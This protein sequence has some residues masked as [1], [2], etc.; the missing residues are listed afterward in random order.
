MKQLSLPTGEPPRSRHVRLDRGVPLVIGEARDALQQD[1][2]GCGKHSD[3]VVL[4]E[5]RHTST[6]LDYDGLVIRIQVPGRPET[7]CRPCFEREA[8]VRGV[9]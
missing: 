9:S 8:A 1:H 2:C 3:C 5:G 6:S 4:R 7:L